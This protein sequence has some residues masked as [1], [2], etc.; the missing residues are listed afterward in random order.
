MNRRRAM[1]QKNTRN[2]LV[3]GEYVN[4][5]S[6][7]TVTEGNIIELTGMWQW[8]NRAIPFKQPISLVTGDVIRYE[9]TPITIDGQ[10]QDIRLTSTTTEKPGT[11][12][13]TNGRPGQGDGIYRKGTVT[14]TED[15]TVAYLFWLIR[16]PKVTSAKYKINLWL[17]ERQ[18]L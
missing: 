6:T 9:I 8:S 14:V 17:N 2:S 15:I 4:S 1:M 5:T 16:Y 3:D 10:W 18:I 7:V 13:I 12:I 11:P